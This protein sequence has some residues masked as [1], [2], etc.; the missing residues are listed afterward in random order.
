MAVAGRIDLAPLATFNPITDPHSLS[1]RWKSWKH[2]FETYIAA[3][4][5]TKDKQKREI[6]LY[7]VR[8]AKHEIFDTIPDKGDDFATAMEKLDS[9]F[10]PKKM[11]PMKSFNLGR[12]FNNLVR[13]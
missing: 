13:L 5:L 3:L 8:E 1:Q 6:L 11:W 9:Y 10:N 7:R 2:S 4:N 12:Q